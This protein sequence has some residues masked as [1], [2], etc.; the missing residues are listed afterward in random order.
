MEVINLWIIGY[1]NHFSGQHK[2]KTMRMRNKEKQKLFSLR[3][4]S[5]ECQGSALGLNEEAELGARMLVKPKA[6]LFQTEAAVKR[7]RKFN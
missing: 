1:Q 6:K 5:Q 3:W 4:V 7:F 2:I